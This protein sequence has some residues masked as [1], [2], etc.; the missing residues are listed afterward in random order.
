MVFAV[1]RDLVLM[2]DPARQ[3][4]DPPTSRCCCAHATGCHRRATDSGGSTRPAQRV[5]GPHLLPAG[6]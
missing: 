6:Q 2:N 4:L 3:V 1:D 5:A